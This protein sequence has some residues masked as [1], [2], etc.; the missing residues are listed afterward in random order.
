MAH[1]I[2][3]LVEGFNFHNR[4]LGDEAEFRQQAQEMREALSLLCGFSASKLL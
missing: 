3:N 2:I 1:L 4:I